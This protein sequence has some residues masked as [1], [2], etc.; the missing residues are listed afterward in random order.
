VLIL[1]VG[2][3]GRLD[4]VN[5]IDADVSV[6]TTISIDHTAWLGD[7]REQI[8]REKAGIFRKGRPA[9][10]GD[11]NPPASLMDSAKAIGAGWYGQPTDFGYEVNPNDWSWSSSTT[12]TRYEK[13]PLNH[14]ATQNMST[15]LMVVTLLQSRLPVRRHA[16]D[17]GLTQVDLPGRIQVMHGPI[18]EIY[19]VSHNPASVAYLAERLHAMKCSKKTL[20]VFSMLSDKDIVTSIQSIR[21]IIDVW[22]VAALSVERAA[23]KDKL[24]KALIEAEINHSIFF[25]SIQEA[26]DAAKRDAHQGDRIIVFGSFH[27]V[28]T[29]WK[30]AGNIAS[31]LSPG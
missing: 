25:P 8:A 4:A 15:V 1:E 11:V 17:Q 10:C 27:T 19:D 16:I 2:L 21:D 24:A 6:V 22:Y 13:L 29:V 30:H 3:G 31:V 9:V 18:T 7:T 26:Y 5:I 14:L 12:R 20:A 23:S 28:A